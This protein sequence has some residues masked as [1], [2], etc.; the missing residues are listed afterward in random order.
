MANRS[1]QLYLYAKLP[2]VGWRYCPAV[3]GAN[4]KPKP[5]ALLRTDNTE[6][7][8]PGADYYLGYR[9]GGNKVWE[10]VGNNPSDAFRALQRKRTGLAHVAVGGVV[11][12]DQSVVRQQRTGLTEAIE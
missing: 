7:H 6:E 2:G 12:G 5:H 3:F 10:N 11:L 8:Y 4:N 1:V 9:N